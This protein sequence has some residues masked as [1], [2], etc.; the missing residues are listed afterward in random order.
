MDSD[1]SRPMPKRNLKLEKLIDADAVRER[2]TALTAE[3]NGDGSSFKSRA[4]VLNILKEASRT[5]REK[6]RD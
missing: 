3:S 4:E 1:V 5:G 6:A 2:L